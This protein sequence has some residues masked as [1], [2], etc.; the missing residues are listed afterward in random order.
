MATDVSSSAR[1]RKNTKDSLNMT[2]ALVAIKPHMLDFSSIDFG[3]LEV[4]LGRLNNLLDQLSSS[5]NAK[6]RTRNDEAA[7]MLDREGVQLWNASILLR[8]IQDQG[9]PESRKRVFASL[10]LAAFRLIEA[11]SDVPPTV[12]SL[13]HLLQLASKTATALSGCDDDR[14]RSVMMSAADYES[15]LKNLRD[16]D[17]DVPNKESATAQY[18][19]GRMETAWKDGNE[20]VAFFMLEQATDERRLDLMP[21][22][23][24][25]EIL[26]RAIEIGKTILRQSWDKESGADV[27]TPASTQDVTSYADGKTAAVAVKWLQKTFQVLERVEHTDKSKLGPLREALLRSLAR[28]YFASSSAVESNLERAE[29]TV[30]ELIQ[31]K[32]TTNLDLNLLWMKMAI[33]KRGRADPVQISNVLYSILDGLD[34]QETNVMSFLREVQSVIDISVDLAIS[35]TQELLDK[36]LNSPNGSG[37]SFVGT[38]AMSL[39]L[40]V[41][42]LQHADACIAAEK[43]CQS[44]ARRIDFNMEKTS[45]AACQLVLWRNGEASYKGKKWVEAADW[46]VLSASPAFQSMV[47]AQSRCIR[48]AALCYIQQ[49]EYAQ[50]S[51]LISRCSQDESATH[52]VRFLTAVHQGLEEEAIQAVENML[53][54]SDFD[55]KMLLL[56]TQLAHET[57]QKTLL[58]AILEA[59]YKTL[60]REPHVDVET[61]G[62]TLVRCSI[63]ILLDLLKEPLAATLQLI[64]SL[65]NHLQRALDLIKIMASK[66]NLAI[67]AKDL[68]WLWRTAYNAA[69]AGCQDWEELVVAEIFDLARELMEA[70]STTL[71]AVQDSEVRQCIMLSSFSATSG[72]LFVARRLGSTPEAMELYTKLATDVATFRKITVGILTDGAFDGDDRPD[73]MINLF[74]TFEMEV[75]C[76]LHQWQRIKD[77]VEAATEMECVTSTTLEAMADLLVELTFFPV[78]PANLDLDKAMLR[79]SL[80]SKNISIDKFSRW[81]RALCTI[82]LARNRQQDRVSAISFIEQAVE[83]I[84]D[85]KDESGDQMY[86]HDEREWLLH[87]TFNTGV[88]RLAVSDI[89]EAKRWIETATVLAGLVHNSDA[90][91]EKINAVYRQVLAKYGTPN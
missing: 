39:L 22:P 19:C 43:T 62:I 2:D 57:K 70:Y 20:S 74:F 55:R 87:I 49:G 26:G 86:A 66:N 33:L 78:R 17:R 77:V 34:F 5:R 68:S 24:V 79:S 82:L 51:M 8:G 9:E 76:R 48:K 31:E 50:A 35:T 84:K 83:V 53:G 90:A 18:Y 71:A 40:I 11:G 89:Q 16:D 38:I 41:K 45:A 32:N 63:R 72:R 60:Q 80:K 44:I 12:E 65:K 13:V 25:E 30:N 91:S 1:K 64:E 21:T 6:R 73:Y 3:S 15:Q 4:N 23:D 52:Y 42:S 59:M 14:A 56:A 88:E 85:N 37:H 81:L 67:I 10:R 28:A 61:E 36:A 7:D 54:A 75:L 29:A 27:M 58:L 69:V 46:F 47:G